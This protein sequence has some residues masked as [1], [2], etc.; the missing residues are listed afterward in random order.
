MPVKH[1]KLAIALAAALA[2][3]GVGT[4]HAENA[5]SDIFSVSGY[6]TI[7]VVHSSEDRADFVTIAGK[8]GAGYSSSVAA[9]PDSRVALQVDGKFSDQLSGVVQLASE[10]DRADSYKPQLLVAN[11]KYQFTPAFSVNAGRI[12]SPDFMLSDSQRI[13]YA[14]PWVR[15]PSEVY[16]F[17]FPLDGVEANYR[18]NLGGVAISSQAFFGHTGTPDIN[19]IAAKGINLQ[20]EM[21]PSSLRVAY[22][23]TKID[24]K[25]AQLSALLNYYRPT[26]AALA[27]QYEVKGDALQFAEIGY[28]YDPGSWFFRTEVTRLTGVQDLLGK[29][30]SMY[31]SGGF[32]ID[33]FTPY[34]TLAKVKVD[35]PLTIGSADPIG[36]ING[37]LA[38]TNVARKSFTVGT[39]WDFRA[40]TALKLE[41]AQVKNDKGSS[42]ALKN[43]Q[44]NFV[45]GK[46]YN[47]ISA[48]VDFVF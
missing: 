35:S 47:L 46:S 6:G 17:A 4:S 10:L 15:P 44:P 37:V 45:P 22:V 7:G 31:A 33:K 16:S 8:T 24:L 36:V 20:A 30:T 3:L 41:F 32:R 26:F 21:G 1:D 9:S 39:R 11:L 40:N 2:L 25:S 13:G 12:V 14:F 42:G 19:I 43:L 18:F 34:V 48:S 23:R 38:S 28:S 5:G 29:N 27:D